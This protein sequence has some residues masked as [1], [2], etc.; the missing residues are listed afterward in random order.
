MISM[1]RLILSDMMEMD[2]EQFAGKEGRNLVCPL[3]GRDPPAL[4]ILPPDPTS[5]PPVL[6]L[7]SKEVKMVKRNLSRIFI[8]Q[9]KRGARNI[10]GSYYPAP[11]ANPLMMWVFPVPRSPTNATTSPG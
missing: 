5:S 2:P 10:G 8:D 1:E 3:D 6:C 7:Q 9:C 11:A 4:K